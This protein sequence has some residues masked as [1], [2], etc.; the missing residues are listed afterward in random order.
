MRTWIPRALSGRWAELRR[1]AAAADA[2]DGF[3]NPNALV[4]CCGFLHLSSGL[5]NV[6]DSGP[7]IICS[8]AEDVEDVANNDFAGQVRGLAPPPT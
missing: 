4:G 3:L 7:R 5:H 8:W 2:D 6:D 1:A